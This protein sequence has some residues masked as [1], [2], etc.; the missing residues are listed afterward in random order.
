MNSKEVLKIVGLIQ[1]RIS[2]LLIKDNERIV[3]MIERYT[4]EIHKLNSRV[5][6]MEEKLAM[7]PKCPTCGRKHG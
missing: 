6:R 5:T 3:E 2:P 4:K 7:D 1:E